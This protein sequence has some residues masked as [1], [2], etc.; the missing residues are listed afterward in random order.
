MQTRTYMRA[1]MALCKQQQTVAEQIQTRHAWSV[2]I[3]HHLDMLRLCASDNMGLRLP[4]SFLLL[5]LNRD[6]DSYCFCRHWLGRERSNNEG[7]AG[8]T[9]EGD[10]IYPRE[11]NSRFRDV[12]QD[13]GEQ[14]REIS[15][16]LALAVI[17]M[18]LVAM[19]DARLQEVE[20]FADTSS[21]E[22]LGADGQVEVRRCIL[23]SP[24]HEQN[25]ADQRRQLN[26]LLDL[27]HARNA[28]IVPA[29]LH[30]EP[31]L[32]LPDPETY[33]SGSPSE[34]RMVLEFALD[35]W[36]DIPGSDSILQA[37]FGTLTPLYPT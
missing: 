18:R 6:D 16:F 19:Y 5:R 7:H 29:L 8:N 1:R 32:R 10:W 21:S 31:L 36:R 27:L 12:T 20:A 13:V 30:P 22:L 35:V 4:T 3:D 33:S 15:F 28:S 37:R 23:G 34:A 24:D 25:L 17:K 9:H 26:A 11:A 14:F 2:V